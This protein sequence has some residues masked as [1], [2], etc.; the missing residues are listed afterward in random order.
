[1]K[2]IIVLQFAFL[3][4]G[5][6]SFSQTIQKVKITDVLHIA[7]TSTS[8]LI[9]N[10]WAT[11]CRPCVQELPWFEKKV[12]NYKDK[13]VKLLLVSLDYEDDYPK[14]IA[15]FIKKNGYTSKVAWLNE[16]DPN[17]FCLMVDKSWQGTIP[18]TLMVNNA[19]HYRQFYPQQLPEGQ[20][21]MALDKLVE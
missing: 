1:M 13:G 7:D 21:K 10:F 9:I 19:K 11:W 15:D 20:L 12:P 4:A 5:S 2:K 16:T 6:F 8:P 17:Y 14:G 18:A 3:F